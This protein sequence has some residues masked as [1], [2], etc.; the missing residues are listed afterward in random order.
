MIHRVYSD[1]PK[2]K[3]LSFH[4]GLNILLAEK[5]RRHRETNS[6]WRGQDEP[7]RTGPFSDGGQLRARF[8][9]PLRSS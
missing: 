2:F 5:S 6:Q 8:A 3:A 1:L 4:R 9:V 7:N